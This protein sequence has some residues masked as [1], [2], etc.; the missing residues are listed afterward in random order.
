MMIHVGTS[1][2][3]YVAAGLGCILWLLLPGCRNEEDAGTHRAV[4]LAVMAR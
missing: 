3:R 2:H 1:S 4:H